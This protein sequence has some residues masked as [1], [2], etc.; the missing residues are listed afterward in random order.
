[1]TI[2]RIFSGIQPTGELHLGNYF[3][4]VRNWVELQERCD[5]CLYCVVDYHAITHA[6]DG[7]ELAGRTLR[8]TGDLIA[9][10][11]DPARS[12]LF[13]Q[14]HVPEHTELAWVFS[15]FAAYG[16]L[17][18]MTQFKDKSA[19]SS[20]VNAGLFTYPVLQA[21]DILLY[22]ADAVPVGEDQSQH[23]E[24]T[25][26]I[27]RR[28]NQ[29]TGSEFFPEVLTLL[30]EGKRIMSLADPESKMSKSLGDKHYVGIMEPE[31]RLLKKVRS[32]VTDAGG[33][34][35]EELSAG[36]ANL[37]GLLRLVGDDEGADEMERDAL[38]GALL[39]G[40]L[41][42]RVGEKLMELLTPIRERR[43]QLDDDEIRDVLRDGAARAREIAG[44]TMEQ[45]RRLIGVGAVSLAD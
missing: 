5:D 29:Q 24:L 2:E 13:A 8:L 43:A 9:C 11:I 21:A 42:V 39:Y 18:R 44:A 41:K 28:F 34:Q 27:A 7:A 6:T 40:H 14:S 12:I 16:D 26:G 25:R 10:G 38:A 45:V 20:H 22:R 31:R 35:T 4:A 17:T 36:V 19:R 15:S 1:M 33:E 23:L 30:T 3:G 37:I 32:A